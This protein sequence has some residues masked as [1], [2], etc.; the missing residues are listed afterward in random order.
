MHTQSIVAILAFDIV[1]M[2]AIEASCVA[3]GPLGP[4]GADPV[5]PGSAFD[6]VGMA[7][8]PDA[9]AELKVEE[10]K[11]GRVAMFSFLGYGMQAF[12]TG[13]WPVEK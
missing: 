9:L 4:S 2:G 12:A 7:S 13:N 10:I 6:P 11:N 5:Y 8:E 3:G 1:A